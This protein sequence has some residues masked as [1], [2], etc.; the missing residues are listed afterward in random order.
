MVMYFGQDGK[1]EFYPRDQIGRQDGMSEVKATKIGSAQLTERAQEDIRM[2]NN[3][4]G[5]PCWPFLPVK[6]RGDDNCFPWVMG[7][8][9]ETDNVGWRTTV[10][11]G[12]NMYMFREKPLS[13]CER[14]TY[15]S[16]EAL[17]ADGW[18]VD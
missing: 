3:P 18:M 4:S 7:V 15:E 16:V 10:Y 8:I 6:K 2:I 13:A 11:V 1:S 9:A 5:W 14:K 12:A 17:V